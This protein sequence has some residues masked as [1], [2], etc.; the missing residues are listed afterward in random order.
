MENSEL[1]EI[2]LTEAARC[3]RGRLDSEASARLI[4]FLY[5]ANGRNHVYQCCLDLAQDP[6]RRQRIMM[7]LRN[8]VH[9]FPPSLACLRAIESFCHLHSTADVSQELLRLTESLLR[10]APLEGLAARMTPSSRFGYASEFSLQSDMPSAAPSAST[11]PASG[12]ANA[13]S[14]NANHHVPVTA[15]QEA[16]WMDVSVKKNELQKC[17]AEVVYRRVWSQP[18]LAQ[19]PLLCLESTVERQLKFMCAFSANYKTNRNVVQ[20]TLFFI[21]QLCDGYVSKLPLQDA[22]LHFRSVTVCYVPMLLDMMESDYLCVRNHVYDFI[23]NLGVH[24]QLVDPAGVYP[25]CTEA[26]EQELVWLLLTITSRQAVLKVSDETTWTAAAKCILAVM[27]PPYQYLTDCRVLFQVLQL[28][29]LWELYPEAF[30]TLAT[31]FA[32]SLLRNKDVDAPAT[33]NLVIDEAEL[34]KLGNFAVPAILT[35]YRHSATPGSRKALFQLLLAY[36][37]RRQGLQS[38]KYGGRTA[39]QVLSLEARASAL[40]DLTS[41]DFFWYVMPL[42]YYMSENVQ[43]ELPRR[44]ADGLVKSDFDGTTKSWSV[45]LPMA[46]QV[47]G[48]LADDAE[49]ASSVQ[50]RFKAVEDLRR[51]DE[52]AFMAALQ[53]LLNEVADTV[54]QLVEEQ[55]DLGDCKVDSAAWRLAFVSLRWSARYLPEDKHRALTEKLTRSLVDFKDE[56]GRTRSRARMGHLC[57]CLLSSLSVLCRTSARRDIITF[58]V[59]LEV[60]LFDRKDPLEVRTALALYY[61]LMEYICEP[62]KQGRYALHTSRDMSSIS[63]MILREKSLRIPVSAAQ[64]VSVRVLWGLYRSLSLSQEASVCRARHV[65]VLM[66]ANC[67]TERSGVEVRTW[68]TVLADPYSPVALLAAEKILYLSRAEERPVAAAAA[69]AD[70]SADPTR[71]IYHEATRILEKGLAGKRGKPPVGFG[72]LHEDNF[73]D[74]ERGERPS[75]KALREMAFS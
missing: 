66:L 9:S 63:T 73:R 30:S 59:V 13:A 28:P 20:A 22:A 11:S 61:R 60:L 50:A 44:I 49:L 45:V 56:R 54:P 2:I 12:A 58:R 21:K 68:K 64:L 32:R 3:A 31:A 24:L 17:Y 26:L 16:K 53:D 41:V 37:A 15:V 46:D 27:P 5:D 19:F 18:Y 1:S 36:A 48:V 55:T 62:S 4:R 34:A 57:I 14:N 40:R 72:L 6:G 25:G 23:L 29:G 43:R 69:A 42:L 70:A 7:L 75:M 67:C 35:V 52:A 33:E 74:G 71:D 47:L 38:V 8:Y 39:S 10:E 51:K 65:L